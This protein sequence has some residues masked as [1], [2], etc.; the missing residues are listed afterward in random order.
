MDIPNKSLTDVARYI[1]KHKTTPLTDRERQLD[2]IF[3]YLE[4]FRPIDSS[5]RM[6]EVGTGMGWFPIIATKRGLNL[7]GLEISA[8]LI[9]AAR[10]YGR[11]IGA[12]PN[13]VQGNI[14]EYDL[15]ENVYDVII[16]SSVFEHVENWRPALKTMHRALKPGGLLF[17]ESTNRWSITSGEV[18]WLPCYGWMPDWMRFRFRKIVHGPDIMELGI[19]FHQFTYPRLRR[20]F[21]EVGFS[22]WY[23]RVYLSQ[24]ERVSSTVKRTVLS[25]CRRNAVLRELVLTFFEM[26]TFVCIK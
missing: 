5:L 15:G 12:E 10:E 21:Q 8:E 24:P 26:T 9:A 6:I 20:A 19:D 7:A 25:W 3:A 2:G 23:D 14:E 22:Q 17:F 16:A 1:E 4:L 18:P 13:I 11:S